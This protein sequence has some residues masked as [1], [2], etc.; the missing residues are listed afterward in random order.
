MNKEADAAVRILI[1]SPDPTL[2][3][4]I[5]RFMAEAAEISIAGSTRFGDHLREAALQAGATV[6][7]I[8]ARMEEAAAHSALQIAAGLGIKAVVLRGAGRFDAVGV[9]VSAV[10]ACPAEPAQEGTRGLFAQGLIAALRTAAPRMP[11]PVAVAPPL[12]PRLS[13]RPEIIAFGSSTGG[14]QALAEV[15]RHLIRGIPQPMV[16]TQHMPPRFTTMLAEQINR[17]GLPAVEA[18][19]GLILEP[20]HL[21][22]APGGRHL[23]L[24]RKAERLVCQL[25]DGPAENFCRPAV[26]PMLRSVVRACGGRT[27]AVILTGMGCDGLAG[28]R[29]VVKAGGTVLAQDEASSVVWGMPGAVAQAGLCQAVLPLGGI[30][31]AIQ[32]LATGHSL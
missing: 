13:G 22:I 23:L 24:M 29:E 12:G 9:P 15:L 17:S 14:P 2:R 30:A 1:A 10:L 3:M 20:G 6:M 28:C 5:R 27:L 32:T 21:Y 31:K 7:L 26:D 25:D 18:S 4:Q 8:D 16:L 11:R 19:D